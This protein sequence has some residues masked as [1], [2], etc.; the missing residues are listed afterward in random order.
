MG[1]YKCNVDGGFCRRPPLGYGDSCQSNEDCADG[2]ATFCEVI[3]QNVCL[4]PCSAGNTD[5][6]FEGETCC[7]FVIFE[8]ICVPAA[9]CTAN[10]GLEVE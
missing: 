5:V 3:Q 7:N 6:C 10:G 1:G 9:S 2:E 4:V 8:P